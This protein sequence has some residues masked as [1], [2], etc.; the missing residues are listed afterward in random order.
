[1][2]RYEWEHGTIRLPSAEFAGFRQEMQRAATVVA[3]RAFARTQEVWKELPR[4]A[5]TDRGAYQAAVRDWSMREYRKLGDR[6]HVDR[7]DRESIEEAATMLSGQLYDRGAGSARSPQRVRK[8]D[9]GFPTNRTVSFG[10]GDCSVTFDKDTCSVTWDV[11][12]NNHACERARSSTLGEAF[13]ARL[14]K[15]A[16]SPKT[17]G[18]ITGNDEYSQDSLESG[19]G[20]NYDVAGYGPV[21]V[22]RAPLATRGYTDSKGRRMGASVRNSRG[23]LVAKAVQVDRYGNEV[24]R[25]PTRPAAPPDPGS[26]GPQ[27]RVPQGNTRGG[28]FASTSAAESTV[29]L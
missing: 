27:A 15:V 3:E 20:A 23:H 25:A 6:D 11:Q 8:G 4:K 12:E 22:E 24:T 10:N 7:V 13:F 18:V 1:M 9:V 2:S 14:G 26:T 16:W 19:G 29:E 17:G 28:Q 21:G 5:R